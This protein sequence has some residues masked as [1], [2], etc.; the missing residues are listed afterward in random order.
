MNT[1]VEHIDVDGQRV[2]RLRSKELDVDVA[3][4]VGGKIV[5]IRHLGSGHSFLWRNPRLRLQPNRPGGEYDPN[6]Y[7]GVDELLPNDVPETIDGVACPDHGELWTSRLAWRVDGESLVLEG[8]LPLCGLRYRRRMTL[9]ADSPHID[10]HYRIT[11]TTNHERHFLWKLHAALAVAEGDVIDCPAGQAQ[12]IDPAYS[13]FSSLEPFRWPI[14]EGRRANVVPGDEGTV[15]FF[16][17]FDLPSGRIAWKRPSRRLK[18]EYTFDTAVF[19]F[20]WLFASYGGF[21]GH[22]TVVLEPCTTMPIH[23]GEAIDKGTCSR[24]PPHGMLEA[25]VSIYAGPDE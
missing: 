3:P 2:V 9:R 10:L 18:F 20:A 16:Y 6:F 23:V 25:A 19:P 22:Y 8:L 21:D 12:V 5:G 15:D 11:N 14:L 13:R 4:E 1:I 17:L 7:G 24:L